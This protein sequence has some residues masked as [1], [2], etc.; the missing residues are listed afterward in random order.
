MASLFDVAAGLSQYEDDT[1]TS[2]AK[3]QII[4]PQSALGILDETFETIYGSRQHR[5]ANRHLPLVRSTSMIQLQP[6]QLAKS[7]S[8]DTLD[9]R[10]NRLASFNSSTT[11]PARRVAPAIAV[12]SLIIPPPPAVPPPSGNYRKQ[13]NLDKDPD[14]T[15]K[16]V[17]REVT[18]EI[19]QLMT[20][21]TSSTEGEESLLRMLSEKYTHARLV[22]MT[23]IWR[24]VQMSSYTNAFPDLC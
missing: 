20:T 21:N 17:L 15:A 8:S 2:S 19:D 4:H 10:L 5:S 23:Q 16:A 1:N 11:V 13:N 6:T 7:K 3:L 12:A 22:M 18:R 14:L 24:N 9:A